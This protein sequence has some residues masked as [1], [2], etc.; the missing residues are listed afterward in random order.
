MVRK[1]GYGSLDV[2]QFPVLSDVPTPSSSMSH[3]GSMETSW[4]GRQVDDEMPTTSRRPSAL[5]RIGKLVGWMLG[6][7]GGVLLCMPL[8]EL[9]QGGGPDG[10]R[11]VVVRL[12]PGP[13]TLAAAFI[14]YVKAERLGTSPFAGF[15]AQRAD[16]FEGFDPNDASVFPPV[17]HSQAPSPWATQASSTGSLLGTGHPPAQHMDTYPGRPATSAAPQ[18]SAMTEHPGGTSS[19]TPT[20]GAAPA[21]TPPQAPVAYGNSPATMPPNMAAAIN[22]PWT[23]SHGTSAQVPTV[24]GRSDRHVVETY[25]EWVL[26]QTL[27]EQ[28]FRPLG[29]Q[30]RFD[31]WFLLSASGVASLL[32]WT[33]EDHGATYSA[34]TWVDQI[35]P[36]QGIRVADR[37]LA[38]DLL[39]AAAMHAG[40]L[41][42]APT[43]RLMSYHPADLVTAM[44][45]L[46]VGLL[47]LYSGLE[48]VAPDKVLRDQLGNPSPEALGSPSDQQRWLPPGG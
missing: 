3:N 29:V 38:V 40:G 19:F 6:V 25:R 36:L 28:S 43:E 39:G 44:G 30:D 5:H 16:P 27:G 35:L 14:I 48:A 24:V 2:E 9:F 31:E 10:I 32:A 7:I 18:M 34:E 21:P 37:Q 33:H 46:H 11:G 45:T 42:T 17:D 1:K 13:L 8:W 26:R 41:H 15:D 22:E 4:V 12:L 20:R 23:S 47:R